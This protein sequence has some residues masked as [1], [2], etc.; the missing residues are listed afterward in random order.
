[1]QKLAKRVAQAE[2]Q[3]A[4]R[5]DRALKDLESHYRRRARTEIK[6][7]T[8]EVRKHLHDARQAQREEWELG[9]L[10]PARDI[11]SKKYGLA[12]EVTRTDWSIE[13]T[14]KPK[15][16]LVEKRCAWAGG[17]NMLSLS[18]GDRVV[19]LEGRDKDK[20]DTID[21]INKDTGTLKL[22]KLNKVL[23]SLTLDENPQH[24]ALPLPI[25]AVRLVYPIKNE[26]T[27][28]YRD[29]IISELKPIAP[30]MESP[31]MDLIRW[32]HGKKW[33]R[34]VPGLNVV[35]PWPDLPTPK[36]DDYDI[37]TLRDKVEERTFYY[38]MTSSPMPEKVIDELRNKYSK[39]R[40]RHEAWYIEQKEQEAA[41]KARRRSGEVHS[42]MRTPLDELHEKHR[43]LRQEQG[44]PQLTDDMLEK[45][46]Q[47]MAKRSELTRLAGA[48]KP[49]PPASSPAP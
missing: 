29:T 15:K 37:D 39:F 49:S 27:G 3:V 42:S 40:T 13:G 23:L 9:P 43:K 8:K 30:D 21:S 16:K 48:P 38:P 45:I 4:R 26:E 44:E 11:G 7:A 35:I 1:M 20:I 24:E 12:K 32:E 17:I 25:S 31:T 46:G 14:F 33:D 2:R 19:I 28:K 34:V 6:Q 41:Y 22:E 5:K 47:V 10:A 36:H 18:P